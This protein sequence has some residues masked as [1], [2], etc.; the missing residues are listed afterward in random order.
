M[1]GM[2][3]PELANPTLFFD[4]DEVDLT[5]FE[6]LPDWMKK[7]IQEGVDFD[8]TAFYKKYNSFEDLEEAGKWGDESPY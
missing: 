6:S 7:R 1:K 3:V 4:L 2:S 8:K 5:T